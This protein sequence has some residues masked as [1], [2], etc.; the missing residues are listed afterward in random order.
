MAAYSIIKNNKKI[1]CEDC[2]YCEF[3]DNGVDTDR[4]YKSEIDIRC[5]L[6]GKCIFK[7]VI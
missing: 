7:E 5:T 2:P 6:S 1:K 4:G 3:I